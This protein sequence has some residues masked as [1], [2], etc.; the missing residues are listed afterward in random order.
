VVLFCVLLRR[1]AGRLLNLA[2]VASI[3]N[4]QRQDRLYKVTTAG[5]EPH[6]ETLS[7]IRVSA[8]A[9]KGRASKSGPN[10]KG[11]RKERQTLQTI[12]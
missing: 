9:W 1:L 12:T 5:I 6:I 11:A 7:G 4:F 3:G 10:H 2:E 8:V